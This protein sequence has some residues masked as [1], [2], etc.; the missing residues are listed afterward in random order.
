MEKQWRNWRGEKQ[1]ITWQ[2]SC[3]FSHSH[4]Q[5]DFGSSDGIAAQT[6]LVAGNTAVDSRV[7]VCVCVLRDAI[8]TKIETHWFSTAPDYSTTMC[9]SSTTVSTHTWKVWICRIYEAAEC[10]SWNDV[11]APVE[12]S[13]SLW[14]H[15]DSASDNFPPASHGSNS[16]FPHEHISNIKQWLFG[17]RLRKGRAPMDNL[18][19][20]ENNF[21]TYFQHHTQRNCKYFFYVS[22]KRK[23][24]TKALQSYEEGIRRYNQRL[25]FNR[26]S[27][28]PGTICLLALVW[29]PASQPESRMAWLDSSCLQHLLLSVFCNRFETNNLWPNVVK[30]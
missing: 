10:A 12:L 23:S 21:A 4:C 29:Q 15:Q 11:A 18:K 28:N 20:S 27:E 3:A 19:I 16:S 30:Q 6:F 8:F 14:L 22:S 26:S 1:K 17:S 5:P 7:C 24:D 25:L 13:F 2:Q 9:A